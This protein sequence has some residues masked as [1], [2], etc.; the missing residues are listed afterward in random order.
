MLLSNF[1]NLTKFII[2]LL[3]FRYISRLMKAKYYRLK[4]LILRRNHLII[5]LN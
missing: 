4:F 5:L 2:R 3:I 1:T